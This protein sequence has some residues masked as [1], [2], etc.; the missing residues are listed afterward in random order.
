ME[1]WTKNILRSDLFTVVVCRSSVASPPLPRIVQSTGRIE[2]RIGGKKVK[3]FLEAVLHVS[4][5]EAVVVAAAVFQSM[6]SPGDRIKP[7]GLGEADVRRAL[8]ELSMVLADDN[9]MMPDLVQ[10]ARL[11][12]RIRRPGSAKGRRC[13]GV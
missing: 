11:R 6:G 3:L 9:D 1:S 13:A 4:V 8:R 12:R 5:G 2:V 10:S 7:L